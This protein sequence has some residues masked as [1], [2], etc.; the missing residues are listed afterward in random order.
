MILEKHADQLVSTLNTLV[1]FDEVEVQYNA[2]GAIFNL[3]AMQGKRLL[4]LKE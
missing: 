1:N 4:Y 3:M 2:A